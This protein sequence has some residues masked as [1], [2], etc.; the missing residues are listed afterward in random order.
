MAH[1]S[2]PITNPAARL[3]IG[4]GALFVLC[5]AALHVLR[6]DL[7]PSWHFISDYE[8]GEWGWV[9]RV[10]FLSLAASCFGVLA[11][12]LPHARGILGRLGLLLL[13]VS[14]GG[15][16]LAGLFAPSTTNTLHET[17]AVLDQL[18]F[19]ALFISFALWRNLAWRSARWTLAWSLL[20]L[21]AGMGVFI[22]AMV[23]MQPSKD[24][25]P[26]PDVL[27]G[28]PSRAFVVAHAA[29]LI[30][31]AWWAARIGSARPADSPRARTSSASGRTK[32]E[33]VT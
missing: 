19:A 30:A 17:G 15:I 27:V 9:M 33:Q 2:D 22:C 18:P 8:V 28:W 4:A 23:V 16:A 7:D 12:L 32:L 24:R 21:W 3:A 1:I 13:L 26:S 6:P 29:W 5:L 14:G 11:A 25:P 20:V 10:A 31:V